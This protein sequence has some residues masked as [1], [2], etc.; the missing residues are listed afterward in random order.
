MCPRP[1]PS[2]SALAPPVRPSTPGV[3]WKESWDKLLA[4]RTMAASTPAVVTHG[5]TLKGARLSWAILK[6]RKVIENRSIKLSPGWYALHTGVGKMD[7]LRSGELELLCPGIP[8]EAT[9][10]HGER[11]ASS[12]RMS[13]LVG[14]CPHRIAPSEPARNLQSLLSLLAHDQSSPCPVL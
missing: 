8:E 2:R 3:C 5:I 7:A 14:P 1:P 4:R 13:C 6:R 11:S 12:P 9:L 10:P